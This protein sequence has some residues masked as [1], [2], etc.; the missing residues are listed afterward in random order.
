MLPQLRKLESDFAGDVVVVGVHS[1]K[2]TAERD[3]E[4][5]RAAVLAHGVDHPV[6]SDPDH[7]TWQ[8]YAVRAWPT[9]MFV[10]PLGRVVAK[11][12]GEL[13]YPQLGEVVS[14]MVAEYRDNG[15]LG[16]HSP[17]PLRPEPVPQGL[18]AFPGKVAVDPA[19]R[20]LVVSDSGHHKVLV[21]E[22]NLPLHAR[23]VCTIGS[24]ERGLADG[25][26]APR[27]DAPQGLALDG[28]T[29]YVAD[30]E[31]HAI[32]KVML[33]DGTVSTIAGTGSQATRF[34]RG[35]PALDVALSSPW[36]LALSA[37]RRYL[38]VAM[39]G[40]HQVWVLDLLLGEIL[41]YSGTGHEGIK[42]ETR[43]KA[44]HA[45]PYGL[46]L[47]GGNLYVADSETSAV[48]VVD[49]ATGEGAVRTLVGTGLF[50]FGDRDGSGGSAL[51][52]HAAGVAVLNGAVWVADSFNNKLRKIDLTTGWVGT[53]AGSGRAG[54]LDGSGELAQLWNPSGL[55]TDGTG[56]Y[57]ADTNNHCIRHY[58]PSS[59]Q[60]STLDLLPLD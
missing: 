51:L 9:L 2:F 24:G 45:Q 26:S 18:L 3:L 22:L 40:F 44:W 10:D 39:A 42:D 6:V 43:A 16:E 57:I 19:R 35:G 11:H 23:V 47:D 28:E 49:T 60:L 34:H 53:A 54:A 25:N 55:C 36:D 31:N 56:L 8:S 13:H 7:H 5:V 48:R 4:N 58:N 1:P 12:E 20:R 38:F 14:R 27:F 21:A 41:P 46:G 17:L 37:D 15:L 59:S 32:R 30:V 33:G 50:D 52:Q 29:L